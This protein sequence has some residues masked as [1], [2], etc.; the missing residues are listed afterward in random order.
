M[1]GMKKE[2]LL[3]IG[4]GF[5]VGL[6]ITYG[7]WQANRAIN[8]SKLITPAEEEANE[9]QPTLEVKKTNLNLIFPPNDLISSEPKIILRGNYLPGAEIAII[10]ESQEKIIKAD[11]NGAFETEINLTPGE[12]QIEVFGFTKEGEEDKQLITIVH[13]TAEI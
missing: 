5:I 8:Q 9:A 7:V 2:I 12:N 11:P 13:S 6:T 1:G 10:Q 4:V 3:A